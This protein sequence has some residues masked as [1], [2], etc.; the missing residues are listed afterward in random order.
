MVRATTKP[1]EPPILTREGLGELGDRNLGR[2]AAGGDLVLHV[3]DVLLGVLGVALHLHERQ[4][5]DPEPGSGDSDGSWPECP[6]QATDRALGAHGAVL[7][8][9]QPGHQ[10]GELLGPG[11]LHE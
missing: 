3:P 6:E 4:R 5:Q 11:D 9:A 1:L 8:A 10:P 2:R 7:N